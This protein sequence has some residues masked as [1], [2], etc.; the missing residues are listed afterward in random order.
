MLGKEVYVI[1]PT[2]NH[3]HQMVQIIVKHRIND[4]GE[5]YKKIYEKAEYLMKDNLLFHIFILLKNF[6]KTFSYL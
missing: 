2:Y 4:I 6:N 5:I 1:G 3:Q